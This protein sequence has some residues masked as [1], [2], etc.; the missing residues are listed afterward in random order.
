MHRKV[1][2]R[3]IQVDRDSLPGPREVDVDVI[4]SGGPFLVAGPEALEGL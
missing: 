1:R 4:H 2:E 3:A